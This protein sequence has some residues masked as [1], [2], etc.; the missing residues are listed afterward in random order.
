[1][2]DGM[3]VWSAANKWWFGGDVDQAVFGPVDVPGSEREESPD[4][5]Q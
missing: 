3:E 2:Q 5:A 1:M 4:R